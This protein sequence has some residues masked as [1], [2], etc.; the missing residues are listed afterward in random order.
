M[1]AV[2]CAFTAPLVFAQGT[3]PQVETVNVVIGGTVKMTATA[4]GTQP[5]TYVWTFKG[6][7]VNATEAVIPNATGNI[8]SVSV[9]QPDKAGTYT[10]S[11]RNSAGAITVA[12][13]INVNVIAPSAGKMT[14][15]VTEPK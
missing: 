5:F 11:I 2:V 10:A 6:T 4:E 8:L 12:V 14:T 13:R 1:F 9:I 3:P 7:G 15:I